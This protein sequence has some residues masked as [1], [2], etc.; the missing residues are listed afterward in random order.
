MQRT[1][2]YVYYYD[3]PVGRLGIAENGSAITHVLF[4]GWD[5]E[6]QERETPGIAKAAQ[7]LDEYFRGERT[8]FDLPIDPQGTEFQRA[9]WKALVAIPYGETRS[10]SDQARSV[11]NPRACRA[12]GSA[13]NKNPIPFIIPCHR[14]VGADGKLV[15]YAGGIDI[16]EF[17]LR[18][19][20]ADVARG[21]R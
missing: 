1:A 3:T 17:L 18:L 16:K 5:I 7:Q 10:Y 9:C 2:I 6:A 14:V 8:R 11:G 15:G 12:V 20:G 19:E 4:E 21:S 13:N